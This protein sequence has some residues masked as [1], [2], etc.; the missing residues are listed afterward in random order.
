MKSLLV[1]GLRHD[2]YHRVGCTEMK[3]TIIE[4]AKRIFE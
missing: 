2:E 3:I 1:C 4:T